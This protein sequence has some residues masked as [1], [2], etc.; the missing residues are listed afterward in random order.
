[1][2]FR[3]VFA[4]FCGFVF[5][6]KTV[7][8]QPAVIVSVAPLHSAV[9]AVMQGV[10]TPE[11]L[12]NPA[13]SVHDYHLKPSDMQ[14]LAKADILFWG[15]PA[16][17]SFLQKPLVSAGLSDKNVAFLADP[18]LKTYPFRSASTADVDGHFWL[19]PENMAQAARI[20]AEKLAI[21]DPAHAVLYSENADRFEQQM[22]ELKE[23][24]QSKLQAYL[25]RPYVTFH[26]A[27]QYFE[28]SFHLTPI[29]FVFVDPHHA[30]SAGHIAGLREKIRQAG[31]VCLFAEPQFSDKRIK[32]V[33]EDLPV[34][35]GTLDPSGVNLKPGVGF[36]AELMNNLFESFA[37]CFSRLAEQE[38]GGR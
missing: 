38:T 31:K 19:D 30:G 25:D 11:L 22:R 5:F 26:D 10:G 24:G 8:A 18:R 36:Y 2:F 6:G 12:L 9:S 32:I 33:A 15:G 3:T 14:R 21:S 37:G 20:A 29:G 35:F 4:L 28:K 17:E 16:L 27:Y 1:M 13:V 34:I 7:S 23:N